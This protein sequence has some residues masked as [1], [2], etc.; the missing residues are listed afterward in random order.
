MHKE[1][2][3][4]AYKGLNPIDLRVGTK[5]IPPPKPNPLKIPAN[6]LFKTILEILS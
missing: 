2:V 4:V 5:T 6:I 3:D 1:Q